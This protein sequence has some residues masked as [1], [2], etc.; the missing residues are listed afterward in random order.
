M[1]NVWKKLEEIFSIPIFYIMIINMIKNMATLLNK[2]FE[3]I[4]FILS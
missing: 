3:A 2:E 4:F 1:P